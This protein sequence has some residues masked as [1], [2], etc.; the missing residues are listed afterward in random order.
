MNK[1]E[2]I[3]MAR[4]AGFD[5]STLHEKLIVRHSKGSWADIT[6]RIERFAELVVAAERESAEKENTKLRYKIEEMEKSVPE[7]V[8]VREDEGH[9]FSRGSY[10]EGYD[11]GWNDC[12]EA[13]LA[14][15]P[16][17]K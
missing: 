10:N 13:M 2:I 8:E 3:R 16:E 15:A 7:K 12:R 1:H 11:N 17:A 4:A 6:D 9:I 14:A 5:Q